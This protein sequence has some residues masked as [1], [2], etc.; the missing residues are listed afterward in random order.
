MSVFFCFVFFFLWMCKHKSMNLPSI[1]T[2]SLCLYVHARW[3]RV[4]SRVESQKMAQMDKSGYYFILY[5]PTVCHFSALADKA[6]YHSLDSWCPACGKCC[7]TTY[8]KK[9]TKKKTHKITLTQVASMH[10]WMV[11]GGVWFIKL[12]C[13]WL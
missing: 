6:R 9:K 13:C 4:L 8:I 1:Q 12:C 10:F 11:W 5:D 3:L 7:M 2:L